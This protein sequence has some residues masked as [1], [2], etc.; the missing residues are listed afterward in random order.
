VQFTSTQHLRVLDKEGNVVKA[1]APRPVVEYW[2]LE[3]FISQP[4]SVWRLAGKVEAE[5]E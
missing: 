4:G 3:R 2:V 5:E 1:Q